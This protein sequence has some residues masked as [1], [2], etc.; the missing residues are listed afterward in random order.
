METRNNAKVDFDR[1]GYA[2]LAGFLSAEETAELQQKLEVFIQDVVPTMPP[3]RAF[4][5]EKNNRTTLKQ[6]F[7]LSDYDPYFEQ[8][9]RGSK[10]EELAETLLGE[11]MARGNVEYFNKP[12]GVGKPTPPHQDCYYFM[13]TPPQALTFW[14][15]LEDVD[16]ENGCLRY[17]KGSHRLGM[18]PHGRNATLGFSQAITDFGTPEDLAHEVAVPAKVGDVLVHHGMTIH[19]AEANQSP[20]RS[21]RVLGLVYF[22]ESARE[23][24]AAKEAYQKKLREETLLMG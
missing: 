17:V 6:L 24:T 14:I 2:F 10:F 9:L 21:R 12:A 5:E 1:N 19:R 7:H 23:D 8:L 15:P 13:L 11:K 18:R 16:P 22:G 3:E 20:T 4:Y